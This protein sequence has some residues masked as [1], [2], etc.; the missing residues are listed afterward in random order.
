MAI[1]LEFY[2]PFKII[3]YVSKFKESTLF[4]LLV[5]ILTSLTNLYIKSYVYKAIGIYNIRAYMMVEYMSK[6][7]I[8]P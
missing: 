5:F 4:E 1:N 7:A 3:K 6:L 2:I 8:V